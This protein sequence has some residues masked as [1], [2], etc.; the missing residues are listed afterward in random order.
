M[1]KSASI[2]KVINLVRTSVKD[3][4]VDEIN[5]HVVSN[6][7]SEILSLEI[8]PFFKYSCLCNG[9]GTDSPFPKIEEIK[10]RARQRFQEILKNIPCYQLRVPLKATPSDLCEYIDKNTSMFHV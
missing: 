10:E 4:E 8:N 7:A 2:K 3:F 6:I 5:P 1:S 9:G